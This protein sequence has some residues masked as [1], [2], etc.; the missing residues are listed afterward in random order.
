MSTAQ[1]RKQSLRSFSLQ[2]GATH[3]QV[4]HCV[5]HTVYLSCRWARRPILPNTIFCE[6][7]PHCPRIAAAGHVCAKITK[8]RPATCTQ[9]LPLQLRNTCPFVGSKLDHRKIEHPTPSSHGAECI[10]DQAKKQQH[11]DKQ[12][13]AH[14]QEQA[15]EKA[16]EKFKQSNWHRGQPLRL[17]FS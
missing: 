16:S 15:R 10:R 2:I 6:C 1:T 11:K 5:N 3:A 8:L 17:G 13:Q 4:S 7:F 14:E 9:L 12:K